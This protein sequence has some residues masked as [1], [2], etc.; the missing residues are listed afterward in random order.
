[1]N[2]YENTINYL[3]LAIKSSGNSNES[4]NLRNLLKVVIVGF[5]KLIKKNNKIKIKQESKKIFYPNPKQTVEL[6]DTWIEEEKLN[7]PNDN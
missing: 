7:A 1:M 2:N 5:D 6:I 4:Q 3:E